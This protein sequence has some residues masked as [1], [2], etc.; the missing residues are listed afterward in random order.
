MAGLK[1]RCRQWATGNGLVNT[2]CNT[3]RSGA[4]VVDQG[5]TVNVDVFMPVSLTRT[6]K[7]LVTAP[8]E[9]QFVVPKF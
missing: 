1:R 9:P 8:R 7:W 5:V 3:H 2:G 4:V 6:W